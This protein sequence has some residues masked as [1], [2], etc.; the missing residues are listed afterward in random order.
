RAEQP[1]T[2]KSGARRG[3]R[4]LP[5]N[6]AA[7]GTR[8]EWRGCTAKASGF[9]ELARCR[10]AS[11]VYERDARLRSLIVAPRE[12]GHRNTEENRGAMAAAEAIERALHAAR[13]QLARNADPRG[14]PV[15]DRTTPNGPVS[16]IVGGSQDGGGFHLNPACNCRRTTRKVEPGMRQIP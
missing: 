15:A 7:P 3:D 11:A 16:N 13:R 5:V 2:P 12:I 14:G 9:C 6:Q 1:L 8:S 4:A 10:R